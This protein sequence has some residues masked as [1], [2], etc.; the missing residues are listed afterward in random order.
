M[1]AGDGPGVIKQE[2]KPSSK[3]LAEALF[4]NLCWVDVQG[5]GISIWTILKPRKKMERIFFL[6]LREY[7]PQQR[8]LNNAEKKFCVWL[9]CLQLQERIIMINKADFK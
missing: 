8:M 7:D 3:W 1:G 6:R 5:A 9:S 4:V 2:Q